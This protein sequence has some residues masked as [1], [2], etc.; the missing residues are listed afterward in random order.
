M[1]YPLERRAHGPQPRGLE[2]RHQPR[3]RRRGPRPRRRTCSS[4]ASARSC[5]AST[6]GE[7]IVTAAR[8]SEPAKALRALERARDRRH[9]PVAVVVHQGR[10]PPS[11]AAE[12]VSAM[13][14][15]E[16]IAAVRTATDRR[17]ARRPR[18]VRERV[19]AALISELGPQLAERRHRRPARC[20]SASSRRPAA[21]WR[22]SAGCRCADRERL[23]LEV[24]DDALG[25]GPIEKLLAD[26]TV[27]EIMV[28]GPRDVWIE[29]RGRLYETTV[30]FTDEA[31][32]RR[33]ITQASPA[34]SAGGSTSPRRC[35]TR[36]CPTAAA[37][38]RCC[39]RCR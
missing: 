13:E 19:H 7:P 33:I 27:T 9:G 28:N 24:A 3:R 20:A 11:A 12:A 6:P 35:S 5:A 15:R 39:R 34:R 29:R 14:L 22:P 30:R 2:R 23:A 4:R 36:A 1:G 38:T 25:H 10:R 37:S 31:H 8:R 32:L 18:E 26:D 21:C 16:R 17:G